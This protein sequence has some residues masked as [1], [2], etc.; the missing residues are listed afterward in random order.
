[1]IADNVNGIFIYVSCIANQIAA[2]S[3]AD[4]RV[5]K[6][7]KMKKIFQHHLALQ[8]GFELLASGV[9]RILEGVDNNFFSHS[10]S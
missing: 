2:M 7:S 4:I 10:F 6:A 5:G 9:V 1:M 3:P 8:L